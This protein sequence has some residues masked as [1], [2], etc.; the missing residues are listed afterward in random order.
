MALA[1]W[2]ELARQTA[3]AGSVPCQT[4]DP[5]AWWPD[6]RDASKAAVE[7]CRR[8]RVRGACLSYALVPNERQGV[9]GG[10]TPPERE[11]HQF[12]RPA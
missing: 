2:L 10:S 4:A 9:W 12:K 11:A 5:H 6:K 8:C 1:E 3:D 7:L